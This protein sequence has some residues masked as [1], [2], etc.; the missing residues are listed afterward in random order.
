MEAFNLIGLVSALAMGL[1]LGIV[2][3]G[4]SILTMPIL[5]YLFH[6]SPLLAT[7]YSLFIVG[8]TSGMASISHVRMGNVHWKTVLVFGSS[9]LVAVWISRNLLLPYIPQDIVQIGFIHLTKPLLVLVLFASLM[10]VASY[11]ILTQKECVP[12]QEKMEIEYPYANIIQKGFWIGAVTGFIGAGGGFLIVP[13]LVFLAHLPMK[14]AVGTSLVIITLNLL[15]GFLTDPHQQETV[16][17][18][19]L[20]TFTSVSMVGTLIGS[21]FSKLLP[22]EV[23]KQGFGWLTMGIGAFILIK[24]ILFNN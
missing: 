9:S 21:R 14:R 22:N 18:P 24:E 10:I 13:A 8:V 2:G 7:T 11:S 1:L 3:G 15:L 17:W 6:I 4:G 5:V 12:C 16:D 20:F 19:F 23:L